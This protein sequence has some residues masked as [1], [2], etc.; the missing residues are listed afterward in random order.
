[1]DEVKRLAAAAAVGH[2]HPFCNLA[3]LRLLIAGHAQFVAHG[4]ALFPGRVL[5]LAAIRGPG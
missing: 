3:A 2:Y 4:V 5:H 1:M